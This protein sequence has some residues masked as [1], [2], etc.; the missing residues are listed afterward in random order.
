METGVQQS[1]STLRTNARSPR[2][3]ARPTAVSARDRARTWGWRC[4]RP[5]LRASDAEPPGRG[6]GAAA[7]GLHCRRR[8]V[9]RPG[10]GADPSLHRPPPPRERVTL[11]AQLVPGIADHRRARTVERHL[12]KAFHEA[13]DQFPQAASGSSP[14]D[15]RLPRERIARESTRDFDGRHNLPHGATP[16]PITTKRSQ[17][18][19][20]DIV[21]GGVFPT[22]SC[23]TTPTSCA[24]FRSRCQLRS[25]ACCRPLQTQWPA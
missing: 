18:M 1:P 21:P 9:A 24:R 15:S 8:A 10:L 17:T 11:S 3:A 13:R 20:S 14:E 6:R 16:R 22:T 7:A 2:S 23:L 25:Q 12:C 5:V 19:R 4:G